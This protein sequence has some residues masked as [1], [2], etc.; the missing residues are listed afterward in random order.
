MQSSKLGI[1]KGYLKSIESIRKGFTF[2]VKN[3]I[4]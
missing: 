4:L 3:G 2:S 1:G